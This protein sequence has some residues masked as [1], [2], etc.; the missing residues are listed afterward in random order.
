MP[1][2]IT[3]QLYLWLLT[4][5]DDPV[6]VGELNMVRFTRGVSLRYTDSWIDR[7]LFAS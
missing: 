2:R 5:P 6:F 1:Y 7:G 3:D 4:A